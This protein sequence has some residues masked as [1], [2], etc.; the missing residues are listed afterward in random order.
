MQSNHFS[1]SIVKSIFVDSF[2]IPLIFAIIR[3]LSQ[4]YSISRVLFTI[5]QSQDLSIMLRSDY[6]MLKKI[7]D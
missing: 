7:L 4:K 5:P 3:R 6:Q 1:F 2:N